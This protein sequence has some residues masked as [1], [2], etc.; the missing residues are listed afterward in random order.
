MPLQRRIP[1]RGFHSLNRKEF[2]LVNVSSLERFD[3]GSTVTPEILKESGL[4]KKA[5]QPI[6]ILGNGE[7]SKSI[8]VQADK[9]SKS[10]VEKI[11]NAGGQIQTRV[12][13]EAAP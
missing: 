3:G 6:K 10:A 7:L 13:I 9:F 12:Q 11:T 2:Q 1:K 4:V 5:D 8:T